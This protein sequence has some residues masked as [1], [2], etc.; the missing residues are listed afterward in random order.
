[1]PKATSLE[2]VEAA[3]CGYFTA[4]TS[5]EA[6]GAVLQKH[7]LRL[8]AEVLRLYSL[9]RELEQVL[10]RLFTDWQRIGV[11]FK[12]TRYLPKTLEGRLRFSDFLQFEDDWSSTNRERGILIDKSISRSLTTEE[13]ER[14]DALQIYA[15]HH[16]EQVAPRPTHVL[17]DLERRLFSSPPVK[18]RNAR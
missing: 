17:D 6:N 12:Q 10:L 11:P 14:L 15:D 18:D 3:A 16:I 7:L 5:P 9:P 4:A 13:Q 8:D 1:M 2:R